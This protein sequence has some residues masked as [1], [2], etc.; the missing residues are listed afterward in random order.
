MLKRRRKL[1][2]LLYSINPE[3]VDLT[4]RRNSEIERTDSLPEPL[5][6]AMRRSEFYFIA[7]RS[8]FGL[9][10]NSIIQRIEAVKTENDARELNRLLR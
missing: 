4:A 9:D 8:T 5:R 3:C 7:P 6:K 2:P 10:V 1:A